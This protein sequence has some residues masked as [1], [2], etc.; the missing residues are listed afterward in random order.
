MLIARRSSRQA[1]CGLGVVQND[2]MKL[3]I[4]FVLVQLM[5]LM[6][7]PH[8]WGK[9]WRGIVPLHSTRADVVRKFNQCANADDICTVRVK[10]SQEDNWRAAQNK[11]LQ[12][13]GISMSLIDGLPLMQLSPGR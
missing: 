4:I 11:R 1:L 12:R 7:V 5:T 13:T 3:R 6:C 9:D 2:L 8:T 10:I